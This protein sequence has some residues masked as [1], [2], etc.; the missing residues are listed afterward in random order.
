M[1]KG[2]TMDEKIKK[3]TDLIRVTSFAIHNYHGSGHLEKI[4]ENAL[5]HRLK[6]KGIIVEQQFPLKVYDE[7]GTVLGSYFVDLFIDSII[8][9]LKACK[10]LADEHIAQLFSYLKSS[11]IRHGVLINFGASKL[12]IKKYIL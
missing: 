1:K 11:R 5:F 6:I 9:E 4:Y 12:E 8:I 7:D 10:C 2:K 3:L